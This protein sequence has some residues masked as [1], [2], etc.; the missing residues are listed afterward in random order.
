MKS[1]RSKKMGGGALPLLFTVLLLTLL[2][3][4]IVMYAWNMLSAHFGTRT[5]ISPSEALLMIILS[6]AL[7]GGGMRACGY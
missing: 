5:M 7:L 4:V 1:P 6:N 2:Q 3:A